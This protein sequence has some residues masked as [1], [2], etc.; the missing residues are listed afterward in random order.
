[1]SEGKQCKNIYKIIYTI[2]EPFSQ[3]DVGESK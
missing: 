1:M 2:S 3:G